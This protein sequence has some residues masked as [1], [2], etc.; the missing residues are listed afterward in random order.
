[1][2]EIETRVVL[3]IILLALVKMILAIDFAFCGGE[4]IDFIATPG[5]TYFFLSP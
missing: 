2:I 4:I 1:M 3:Y 5:S